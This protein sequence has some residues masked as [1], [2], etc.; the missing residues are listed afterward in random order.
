ME[1]TN[2]TPT[3][4]AI[5]PSPGIGHL[6]PLA[7]FAKRLVNHHRFTVTFIIPSDGSPTK[8]QTQ[9]LQ[10]L[11]KSISSIFLPPVNFDDLPTDSKIETRIQLSV[12][13]S[14]T[15]LKEALKKLTESTRLSALVV[16]PFGTLAL[17]VGKELGVSPYIFF[18][19]TAMALS[20]L[21]HM[22]KIDAMYTCEFRDLPDPVQL[23]GCVPVHGKDFPDPVQ[24]R[25]NEAYKMFLGNCKHYDLVGGIIVNSFMELEPGAF[26]AL[27]EAECLKWLDGQP[28]GSVLFVSFG[29]GGT[30]SQEQITELALGLEMSGQRF[31]WVVRSPNNETANANYFN[32]ESA[33]DPFVFLPSGFLDRTKGVG[34]VVSSW[35]PQVEVLSHSSTGGFL[36]H[37]GWNSTLESIV[38]GVPLIGWPLYAEQKLNAVLLTDDLKVAWRVMSNENGLVVREEIAKYARGLIS[39]EDGKKLRNKMK[40]F[41]DAADKA[42]T[43]DG[44]STRSISELAQ[45]W[46]KHT[47]K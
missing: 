23:P 24:D 15:Y 37:C 44:L 40:E 18:T 43:K 9:I 26:K 4:V 1:R 20:L 22:P 21:L 17:D 32:V 10:T 5:C 46:M 19:S 28:S 27:K 33:K 12:T 47:N 35:A 41:K 7:E 3:H 36:T 38:H 31:L 45:N 16:D 39:Q 30:L 25:T 13:R 2:Q 14:L 29:S 11:P 6:I 8:S 42:L 34:V